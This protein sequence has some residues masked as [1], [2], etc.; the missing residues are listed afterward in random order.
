VIVQVPYLRSEAE[1]IKNKI[2]GLLAAGVHPSEII[3]L[4]QRAV[5]GK[6]ILQALR[7]AEIPAKSYY[8]ESQLDSEGVADAVRALQAI[9]Q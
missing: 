4:V 5:A 2:T 1:W 7:V 8:E 6:P 9:S 3:I